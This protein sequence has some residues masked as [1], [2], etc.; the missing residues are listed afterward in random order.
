MEV[1][2][3]DGEMG[4]VHSAEKAKA[5]VFRFWD[6]VGVDVVL[7]ALEFY[8]EVGSVE[9][10]ARAHPA[11]QGPCAARVRSARCGYA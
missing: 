9:G 2:D 11:V 3:I 6:Q 5:D 8:F 7:A 10:H 4:K 1:H